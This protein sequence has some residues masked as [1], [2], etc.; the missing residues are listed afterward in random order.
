MNFFK[1]YIGDYLRDTGTLTLAQH[2]AY[3][4]MLMQH[5]A[6]ETPLP[7]GRELYRL[8]RADT[9]L[10]RDAID[11]V[12][13]K[14]WIATEDGLVNER[15]SKEFSRASEISVKNR[16]IA[17]AREEKKRAEKEH[18][19]STKRAQSVP[20]NE[21]ERSTNQTSR[22]QTQDL[23]S[24]PSC[25]ELIAQDQN[26]S[27]DISKSLETKPPSQIV[28]TAQKIKRAQK[29]PEDFEPDDGHQRLASELGINLRHE[30][31]QFRD[32]HKAR[33][34]T[35]VSWSAALRTW[36]RNAPKFRAQAPPTSGKQ[37]ARDSYAAQAAQARE[38]ENERPIERDITGESERIT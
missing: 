24:K 26:I 4:L 23:N 16:A 32:Y 14:F 28:S 12:A 37:A 11:F 3:M 2:G 19:D 27:T 22:H 10:E 20:R 13:A 25:P 15:S 35:M 36:L 1:L 17:L 30:I 9:K 8:L 5:Y 7:T 29:L 6:N 34:T 18:E 33:G 38:R 21:H 31:L